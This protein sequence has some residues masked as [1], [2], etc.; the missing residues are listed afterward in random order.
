MGFKNPENNQMTQSMKVLFIPVSTPEG[1]GEYARSLIIAERLTRE[2]ENAEI[3]FILNENVSYL[4]SCPFPYLLAKDTPTKD[5]KSVLKHIDEVKPDL[6]FFDASG[7]AE[8]F[9]AAKKQGAIVCFLSQHE[10]KRARGLKFNR[11]FHTDFHWVVQ[12]SFAIR[13][14]SSWQRLKLK[15]AKKSIPKNIGAVFECSPQ[16]VYQNYGLESGEYLLF[17]AGS[18]GHRVNGELASDIFFRTAQV[19]H[20]NIGKKCIVVMGNN[21]PQELPKDNNITVIKSLASKEFVNLVKHAYF[22]VLSGGD[23]LLQAISM[24]SNVLAVAVAKD[25]SLRINRCE[26]QGLVKSA[27]LNSTSIYQLVSEEVNQMEEKTTN[28]CLEGKLGLEI[29]IED[30]KSVIN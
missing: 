22:S 10:K 23:T 9:R 15:L 2:F 16:A 27:S 21:Y 1:I 18:G 11:L 29:I 19:T 7:R 3:T 20:E 13:P 14:L 24:G 12:P 17:N 4:A 28:Q 30:L 6:V 26:Q 5:S 25:Q 8:Q